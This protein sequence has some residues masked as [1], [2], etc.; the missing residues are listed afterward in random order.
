MQW[1]KQHLVHTTC[2]SQLSLSCATLTNNANITEAITTKV[3]FPLTLYVL[4]SLA[5]MLHVVST[6]GLEI[7]EWSLCGHA[8]PTAEKRTMAD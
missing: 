6:Q 2:I 3:C 8:F 5:V 7:K 1:I 4:D